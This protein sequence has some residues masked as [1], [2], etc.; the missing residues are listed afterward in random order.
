MTKQQYYAYIM[1]NSRPTLYTGMT[2]DLVRRVYEHRTGAVDGFT[3]QYHLTK[4]VY[5]EVFDTPLQAIIREKQLKKMLRAEKLNLIKQNNPNLID[6][7]PGL[8]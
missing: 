7:Y 4:L 3:K 2:N 5:Y 6:L 8:T 1:V